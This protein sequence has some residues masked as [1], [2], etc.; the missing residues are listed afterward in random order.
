MANI[1]LNAHGEAKIADF[2]ISKF[3]FLRE[4]TEV[5]K[6]ILPPEYNEEKVF[7][8]LG[9]IYAFGL[10]LMNMLLCSTAR[11][12]KENHYFTTNLFQFNSIVSVSVTVCMTQF[13]TNIDL[14]N[15]FLDIVRR[16]CAYDPQDRFQS[17]AEIIPLLRAV[18]MQPEVQL[19]RKKEDTINILVQKQEE[20][21]T[22]QNDE[23]PIVYSNPI[24]SPLPNS[25]YEGTPGD[26][27]Y[28]D[29]D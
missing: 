2:G 18:E 10:C 17:F 7:S 27:G 1:L 23:L 29:I 19:C 6:F 4:S 21:I 8:T 20:F 24:P 15:A 16:S 22:I 3:E 9:D 28:C 11:V 26:G 14:Q 5:Y 13:Q 25:G 12:Q